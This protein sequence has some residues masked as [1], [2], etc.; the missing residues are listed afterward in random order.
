MLSPH[1]LP[2]G[3]RVAGF[4]DFIRRS[5]VRTTKPHVAGVALHADVDR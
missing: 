2:G 4:T 3:A 5:I 1:E